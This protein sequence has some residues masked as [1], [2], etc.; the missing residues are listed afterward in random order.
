METFSWRWLLHKGKQLA[1]SLLGAVVFYTIIPVPTNWTDFHRIARWAT[2]IGLL[3]GFLLGLLDFGL[4]WLGMPILT[5]S[6]I[7]VAIWIVITGGLHLDGAIDTADGLAVPDSERR[8]EIMR[9]SNTG[10]FGAIAAGIILLLKTTALSDLNSCRIFMLMSAAGWGRW[11][12]LV[13]IALYPYL[14]ETGKGSFHKESIQPLP[15][16]LL[17]LS[18]LLGAIGLQ[19]WLDPGQWHIPLFSLITGSAIA[20][21]TGFYF[22]YRLKGH[23]GDTYGAVVEVRFVA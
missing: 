8:L 1:R 16:I 20:M 15:D 13:A 7:V 14:R 6:A 12:Q 23:T 17:G 22:N 5:R 9:D 10:A 18:F 19:F 3:I 4:S 11:G 21:L 2:S